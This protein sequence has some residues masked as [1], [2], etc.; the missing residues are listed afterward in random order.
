MAAEYVNVPAPALEAVVTKIFGAAGCDGAE[1][2]RI[3]THLL[4]ANLAGHDSHGVARVPRYVEWLE[5]GFVLKGQTAE[6]ITDGGCFALLDGKFGFG[7]TVAPQ[8]VELGIARALQHGIAV[9]GLRN[10][11]HIGRVGEYSEKAIAAGLIS[12]HFV[13]VAGSVLVA[14][15]GGVERRFSTAPFSVGVPLPGRPLILDFATSLVAEG[16]VLV[17]SNGGKELPHDA[18]I[19]PDGRL[20]ADP[21]TLYGDYPQIGPRNPS[22]GKGAIRAFG[23]HKG[24]GLAFM[25]EMLAGALTGGGTSGPVEARGRIANGM[26][27]FYVSPAHFGTQAEFEATGRAYVDWVMETAPADPASPVLAP[28]DKEAQ[29]RADRLANGVPLQPDTWESI[30]QVA[31]RLGVPTN[32]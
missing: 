6:I 26:L 14:P 23:E 1:S 8:A 27:S 4:G 3:S 5:S 31:R 9:V 13:N 11:G 16:K 18:L 25:C 17:A 32:G 19:E 21:H 29:T 10:A 30:L 20:S 12:V 15:F 28:G 24:S 2:T 22:N 7:Q